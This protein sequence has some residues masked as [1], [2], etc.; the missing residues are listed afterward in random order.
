M[1]E[2]SFVYVIHMEQSPYFKV[3]K[4]DDPNAR[5]RQLQTGN[6]H[7]L[8]IVWCMEFTSA[9]A[10]QNAEKRIHRM[11]D[12][13]RIRSNGTLSEWFALNGDALNAL[14]FLA[15]LNTEAQAATEARLQPKLERAQRA[16]MQLVRTK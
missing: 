6:P 11:F 16:F 4:A 9:D 2:N 8:S 12:D 10:A 3:G 1:T 7:T 14:E 15:T 13:Y 5:L